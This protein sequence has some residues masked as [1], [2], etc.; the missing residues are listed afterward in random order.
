MSE[1][2]R[3]RL[4]RMSTKKSGSF[5]MAVTMGVIFCFFV[6]FLISG[7]LFDLLVSQ[8]GAI[9]MTFVVLILQTFRFLKQL[10]VVRYLKNKRS[11]PVSIF[12]MGTVV[13]AFAVASMEP[14][15]DWWYYLGGL[16]CLA[17]ACA[18]SID[19]IMRY[20]EVSTRPLPSFYS[21]KGG[22]DRA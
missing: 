2:K 11:L 22:N 8:T 17:A 1:K 20:N 14:V 13:Y 6:L 7:E 16:A 9:A 18:M 15:E 3:S 21:R 4:R 5:Q 19:L 12:A 10:S